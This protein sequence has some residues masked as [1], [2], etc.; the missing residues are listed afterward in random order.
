MLL[1]DTYVYGDCRS[2]VVIM[3]FSRRDVAIFGTGRVAMTNLIHI[4]LHSG[5]GLVSLFCVKQQL[6]MGDNEHLTSSGLPDLL[7]PSC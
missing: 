3:P 2:R 4:L 6:P 1:R 5:N 7:P